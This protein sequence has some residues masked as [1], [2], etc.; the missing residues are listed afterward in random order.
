M[1]PAPEAYAH[2]QDRLAAR[3]LLWGISWRRP[4]SGIDGHKDPISWEEQCFRFTKPQRM[5][6]L[7][8]NEFEVP[9]F[10]PAPAQ[11]CPDAAYLSDRRPIY[12][13]L[14]FKSLLNGWEDT[15]PG[16]L[17]AVEFVGR[18]SEYGLSGGTSGADKAV[19]VDRW[20]KITLVEP[21]PPGQMTKAHV[22]GYL[23]D[24]A[25]KQICMPNSEVPI[26]K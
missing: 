22:E 26:S 21:P 20:I 18:R 23:K 5:A 8:R 24:C 2:F 19:I 10:C 7:W 14:D 9:I 13:N 25:G 4:C 15:P 11:E 17:Y 12:G 16:G 6:G 3:M 1:M